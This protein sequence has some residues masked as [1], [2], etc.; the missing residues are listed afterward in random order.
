[1]L[2]YKDPFG[3]INDE[4]NHHTDVDGPRPDASQPH[5]F[6]KNARYFSSRGKH[7]FYW[8]TSAFGMSPPLGGQ[9]RFTNS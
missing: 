1:M 8:P 5:S 7:P 6:S 2:K 4:Q 3:Q 9:L